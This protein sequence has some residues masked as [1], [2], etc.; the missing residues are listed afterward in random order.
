MDLKYYNPNAPEYEDLSPQYKEVYDYLL[1]IKD[2]K[3]L[4]QFGFHVGR[5]DIAET[6]LPYF[7]TKV[8]LSPIASM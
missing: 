2:Y 8:E 5:T 3:R 1:E 6:L 4:F 7:E